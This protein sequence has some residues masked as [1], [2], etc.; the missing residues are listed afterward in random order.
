VITAV[1]PV[2]R[3]L[4]RSFYLPPLGWLLFVTAVAAVAAWEWGGLDASRRGGPDGSAPLAGRG[5]CAV[6][7]C[8][9]RR[10]SAL[11]RICR[12]GLAPGCLFLSAGGGNFLAAAGA[13]LAARRWPHAEPCLALA[14]GSC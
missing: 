1:C 8:S 14:T 7:P 13:D 5:V 2:C 6:A 10:R 4:L 9:H 3:F 12:G 11:E